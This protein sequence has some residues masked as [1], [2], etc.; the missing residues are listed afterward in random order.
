MKGRKKKKK[1][2][3]QK[4][5][6]PIFEKNVEI[7]RHCYLPATAAAR[8]ARAAPF[9]HLILIAAATA[10]IFVSANHPQFFHL[11]PNKPS[12]FL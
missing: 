5:K 9:L 6:H 4:S 3:K 12:D 2:L 10:F 11:S 7:E 1:Y 8:R